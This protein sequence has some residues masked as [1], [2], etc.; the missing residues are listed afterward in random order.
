MD[1]MGAAS[2]NV[3]KVFIL[4]SLGFIFLG[5][6]FLATVRDCAEKFAS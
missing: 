1:T 5:V 4:M 6:Q 2:S 3:V